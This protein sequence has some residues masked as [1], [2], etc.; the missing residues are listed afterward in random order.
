MKKPKRNT[1]RNGRYPGYLTRAEV[2][3]AFKRN[4]SWVIREEA[5]GRLKPA[6]K[7]GVVHLYLEEEIRRL[8]G[9][10]SVETLPHARPY[11]RPMEDFDR[12]LPG[13]VFKCLEAGATRVE[14]VV[15][16]SANPADV[17]ALHESWARLKGGMF[18]DPEQLQRIYVALDFL[19]YPSNSAEFVAMV[20]RVAK[21]LICAH[22][23]RDGAQFCNR[24][25]EAY[26]TK[27]VALQ[28]R[29]SGGTSPAGHAGATGHPRAGNASGASRRDPKPPE[30][31]ESGRLY[32]EATSFRGAHSRFHTP[33]ISRRAPEQD[34]T[35]ESFRH[36]I[37][38]RLGAFEWAR[39]GGR[40]YFTLGTATSSSMFGCSVIS[41]LRFLAR[42]PSLSFGAIGSN[43]P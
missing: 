6:K 15:Q 11:A 25:V 40:S 7:V 16:L 19:R 28:Q 30:G 36:A 32:G 9:V 4:K 33:A 10:A 37:S 12:E 26:I 18:F 34:T 24:C 3:K 39:R 20:E 8:A 1:R 22:C 42:E 23:R 31:Y 2:G 5:A 35:D 29:G 14:I 13:K 41:I 17:E 21:D 38:N 27:T 43:S